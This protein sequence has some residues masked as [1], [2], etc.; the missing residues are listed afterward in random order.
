[1]TE[2]IPKWDKLPTLTFPPVITP[3]PQLLKLSKTLSWSIDADVFIRQCFLIVVP[4]L[5]ITPL[6]TNDPLSINTSKSISA[7]LDI[8]FSHLKFF[9]SKF[10][11]SSI[12]FLIILDPIPIIPNKF[13]FFY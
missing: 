9:T 2:P 5:I 3:G 11:S 13:F 8:I 10:T 12:F 6:F 4:F 7:D 1:M